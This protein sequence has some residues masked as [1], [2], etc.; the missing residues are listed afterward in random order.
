MH[1]RSNE[2]TVGATLGASHF[3][4]L[5]NGKVYNLSGD[6]CRWSMTIRPKVLASD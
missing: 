2:G 4:A 5:F 6:V 1:L 3:T